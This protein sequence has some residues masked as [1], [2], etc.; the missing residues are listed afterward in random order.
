MSE[1]RALLESLP[2]DH[3][4][5]VRWLRRLLDVES[6][7]PERG[8]IRATEPREPKTQECYSAEQVAD[9]LK[10]RRKRVYELASQQRLRSVRLGR[11][12][13]FPKSGIDDFVRGA[14]TIATH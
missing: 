10:V 7:S 14:G 13:R 9:L 8:E 6:R 5:S 3:Q 1:L 2:D 11:Q 12:I 4:M